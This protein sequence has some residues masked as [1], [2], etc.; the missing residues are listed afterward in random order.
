MLLRPDRLSPF[1][2]ELLERSSELLNRFDHLPVLTVLQAI[3]SARSESRSTSAP[4][5]AAEIVDRARAQLEKLD[6]PRDI[7]DLRV[8]EMG[9][10]SRL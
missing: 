2:A 9:E 8:P 6:Q 4:P 1:D 5:D 3:R 7:L 10:T